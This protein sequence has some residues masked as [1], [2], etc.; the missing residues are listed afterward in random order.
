MCVCT[1][2]HLYRIYLFF[3]Q[4]LAATHVRVRWSTYIH[5]TNPSSTYIHKTN[6]SSDTCVCAREYIYTISICS[7]LLYVW[8]IH[9]YACAGIHI[10][11]SNPSRNT[12]VCARKYM[13]MVSICSWPLY[14]WHIHE[15]SEYIC[16][17]LFAYCNESWYLYE[18]VMAHIWHIHAIFG[19]HVYDTVCILRWVMAYIW[20]RHGTYLIHHTHDI[21][22][23]Y[24][25]Y[26]CTILFA[27]CNESWH[28]YEWDMVH[29]WMSH[30][31]YMTY[32][33]YDISARYF[34]YI[35]TIPFA[36]CDESWPIYERVMAHMT[37]SR[38]TRST[39]LRYC[40]HIA[41]WVMA[42]IWLRHGTYLI[43]HTHDIFTR[44]SE[45]IYKIFFCI[46]RWVT[47]HT[48]MNEW[49]HIYGIFT[50]YSQYIYKILF[51][52]DDETWQ[53]YIHTYIWMSD[54]TYMTYSRV[55]WSICIR[56]DL[57]MMTN[58]G[59]HTYEKVMAHIWHIHAFFGLHM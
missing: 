33:M 44:Y 11:E 57:H 51:A 37:Y 52:Y 56:Y 54:G 1:W 48:H 7:S 10:F 3:T 18:R 58:H 38:V 12:C 35:C 41:R 22:T 27:Y 47:A 49:W 36:Y 55:V 4:I 25:E 39:Y 28:M 16:T 59:T 5:N 21:F 34:E 45:F 24:S 8:H 15:Y 46:W 2:V 43:Y 23:R 17:I 42:H 6:P 14:V 20:M 19:V 26:M 13:Y 50:R 29:I 53:T 31:T 9:T 30:D 40:L 32:H